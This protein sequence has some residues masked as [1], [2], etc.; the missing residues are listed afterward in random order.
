MSAIGLDQV[1]PPSV[2]RE[3]KIALRPEGV[4]EVPLTATADWCTV[5]SGENVTQGS[6]ARKKSP[7]FCALP[8]LQCEKGT[9]RCVQVRPPSKVTPVTS[10]RA[11]PLEK[12]SCCQLP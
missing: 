2:E 4:N 3:A 8:P 12:R 7:P 6:V 5:P 10:P 11:A 9:I 1:S